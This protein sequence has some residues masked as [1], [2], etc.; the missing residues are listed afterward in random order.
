MYPRGLGEVFNQQDDKVA[1]KDVPYID[2]VHIPGYDLNTIQEP[3]TSTDYEINVY[4]GNTRRNLKVLKHTSGM[5]VPKDQAL[6]EIV[7]WINNL[8]L[9]EKNMLSLS[10]GMHDDE[11]IIISIYAP[12][13]GTIERAISNTDD[14]TFSAIEQALELNNR[15]SNSAECD[16]CGQWVFTNRLR[17]HDYDFLCPECYNHVINW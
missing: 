14:T 3:T 11:T 6:S 17:S 16:K 1:F 15:R 4:S 12:H 8:T 7:D 10:W 13:E 2:E 5:D 9:T